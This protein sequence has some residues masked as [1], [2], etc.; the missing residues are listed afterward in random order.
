MTA[1]KEIPS[2]Q[3]TSLASLVKYSI[4]NFKLYLAQLIL[5]YEKRGPIPKYYVDLSGERIEVRSGMI[6]REEKKFKPLDSLVD[7]WI[8]EPGAGHLS[9]LGDF[10]MGKS[11]FAKH[12]AYKKAI[13]YTNYTSHKSVSLFSSI[14][15]TLIVQKE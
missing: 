1:G 12:Y 11:W 10:G 15:L 4:A 2:I 6:V 7:H 5:E 3:T 9:I 8:S 13:D 14:H